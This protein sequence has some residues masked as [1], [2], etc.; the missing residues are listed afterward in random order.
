M[1]KAKLIKVLI[2]INGTII[3]DSLKWTSGQDWQNFEKRWT[4]FAKARG[5]RA[6]IFTIHYEKGVDLNF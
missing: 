1:N 3:K 6:P 2:L 5:Y 4:N